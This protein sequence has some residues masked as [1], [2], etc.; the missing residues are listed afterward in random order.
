[1]VTG[2]R[3][4]GGEWVGK[5]WAGSERLCLASPLRLLGLIGVLSPFQFPPGLL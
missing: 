2:G 5:L 3:G 1:M 4:D